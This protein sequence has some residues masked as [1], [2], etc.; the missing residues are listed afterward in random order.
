[1]KILPTQVGFL[2]LIQNKAQADYILCSRY[3]GT[4]SHDQCQVKPASRASCDIKLLL[5]HMFVPDSVLG[6]SPVANT[7][8]RFVRVRNYHKGAGGHA[9]A[10]RSKSELIVNAKRQRRYRKV[11]AAATAAAQRLSTRAALPR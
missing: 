10:T 9:E 11:A 5:L 4:Y 3:F 7:K 1:M 6:C 2:L 8:R